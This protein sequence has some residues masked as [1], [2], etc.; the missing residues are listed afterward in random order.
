MKH[1]KSKN[2]ENRK[3]MM[4]ENVEIDKRKRKRNTIRRPNI[5]K[6]NYERI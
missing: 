1:G 6:A 2:R 5:E 4:E 3:S